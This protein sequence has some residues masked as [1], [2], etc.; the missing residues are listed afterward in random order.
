MFVWDW[1]AQTVVILYFPGAKLIT[2]RPSPFLLVVL[3]K[4]LPFTVKTTFFTL[5]SVVSL[6]K[7][8]TEQAII[9]TEEISAALEESTEVVE[10]TATAEDGLVVEADAEGAICISGG[11]TE[12]EEYVTAVSSVRGAGRSAGDVNSL[13]GKS[14]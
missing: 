3:L 7:S 5:L 1:L 10:E 6:P 13:G 12:G 8:S 14:I 2:K 4:F 11:K 9:G